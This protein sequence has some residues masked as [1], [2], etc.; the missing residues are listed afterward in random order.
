MDGQD[1]SAVRLSYVEG[2]AYKKALSKSG[3]Y[4]SCSFRVGAILW[5]ADMSPFAAHATKEN[6]S[7]IRK[8]IYG[9]TIPRMRW[10]RFM[11]AKVRNSFY[12]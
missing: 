9:I 1:E 7:R 6:G 10:S 2:A 4:F 8:R 11:G 3:T 12:R 5:I